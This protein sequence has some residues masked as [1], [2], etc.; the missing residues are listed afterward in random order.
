MSSRFLTHCKPYVWYPGSQSP[1][2]LN[3]SEEMSYQMILFIDLV[4][5]V[6]GFYDYENK[7]FCKIC[8]RFC[9]LN[10]QQLNLVKFFECVNANLVWTHE[11]VETVFSWMLIPV[12]AL[13]NSQQIQPDSGLN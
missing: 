2:A 8:E 10:G 9:G 1:P 7:R 5:V 4:G 13:G 11:P 6:A 12:P 3:L